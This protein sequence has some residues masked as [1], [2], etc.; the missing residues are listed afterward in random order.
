MS[1]RTL[2]TG[3]LCLACAAAL[4]PAARA[5]QNSAGRAA[6][7]AAYAAQA[8]KADPNF[9]GF[10]AARGELLY[11]S[12]HP[13]ARRADIQACAA[14]HGADP[15]KPGQNARTGRPIDPVAVSA[16]PKRFTALDTTEKWFGRNCKEIIGRDCTALEKGDYITYLQSR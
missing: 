7:L 15:T 12:R 2:L 8:R 11:S 9:T 10:S 6:V 1:I 14:C 3:A 4:A 16:N 5:D 13:Q